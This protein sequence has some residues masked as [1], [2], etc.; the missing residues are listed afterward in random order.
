MQRNTFNVIWCTLLIFCLLIFTHT[1]T[2]LAGRWEQE[3]RILQ[4]QTMR[5]QKE[6]DIYTRGYNDGK[7]A[8]YEKGRGNVDTEIQQLQILLQ[9]LQ[10]RIGLLEGKK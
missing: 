7:W 2:Y 8:G 9:D 1:W 10:N 6:S 3:E 5:N 4:N